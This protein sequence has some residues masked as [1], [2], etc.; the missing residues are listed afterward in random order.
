MIAAWAVGPL[1][2]IAIAV[3]RDASRP[4]TSAAPSSGATSTPAAVSPSDPVRIS[5]TRRPTS[6]TSAERARR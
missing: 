2:A 5:A 6:R 1:A 3:T 4:A